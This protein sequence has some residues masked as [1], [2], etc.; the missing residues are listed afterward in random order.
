MQKELIIEIHGTGTHNR[1]AELMAI[2]IS[3]RLRRS[4]SNC[5]IVVPMTF[6]DYRA[7]AGYEFFTTWEIQGPGR[8]FLTR[9]AL[10]Y[11]SAGARR[12]LGVVD[13]M[14]IDVVLDASG[15]AFSDQ[16]GTVELRKL[17]DKMT[18]RRTD[19]P[20]ILL[21]QAFGPF[22]TKEV[23]AL[24][25]ELFAR[26][27]LVCARDKI[28]HSMVEELG[29]PKS[30]LRLYPD[31]TPGVTPLF[32][33]GVVPT[34]AFSALVPNIRMLDKGSS[35]EDYL[36]F[37]KSAAQALQDNRMN[38]HFV[39][40]DAREDQQV[41]SILESRGLSLPVL[42]S[43]DPR[44]LKGILGSAQLVIGSRFHALV[45]ALAQCVP[46]VGVGWSHKY[47]ELFSDFDCREYLISDLRDR[48][49]IE[50]LVRSLKDTTVRSALTL[51]LQSS[52]EMIKQSNDTMWKEVD[53]IIYH[54]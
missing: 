10:K 27:S 53:E 41:V 13:P 8:A 5:R 15:F 48:A 9:T 2:A 11:G 50:D 47:Q 24:S 45:S 43:P 22:K 3:E 34:E 29:F 51:R 49:V 14:E 20:L 7:R 33:E 25:R 37:L 30:K 42:K 52:V 19:T 40:H 39:L 12:A 54:I 38:P 21:P 6:G 1:G 28:S 23:A 32:P 17:L 36:L 44:I 26:A 35:A 46:C 31:F 16:W 4:H 18:R